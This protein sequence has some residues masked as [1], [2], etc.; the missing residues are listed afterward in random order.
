MSETTKSHARA[1]QRIGGGKIEEMSLQA[2]PRKPDIDD[3]DLTFCGRL[4]CRVGKQRPE[5]PDRRWIL[6]PKSRSI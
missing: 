3:A 6:V 2:F 4:F 1:P 5:K